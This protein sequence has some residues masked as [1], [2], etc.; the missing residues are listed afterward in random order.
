MGAFKLVRKV[1]ISIM[2]SASLASAGGLA[3]FIKNNL[4]GSI[5][6]TN[7]GYYKTQAG[8]YWT[9]GS[10]KVRWDM[11][12]TNINLFHAEAPSFNVGC[13][14]ID[15]TFG[16]FSYLKFDKLVD[17]L[18]KI[19]SAAP[20]M[21]F[22]MAIM[23][24]CEQCNTIMTNLEKIA[25][26]LNNFNLNACQASKFMARKMCSAI[27]NFGGA[28]DAT[29]CRAKTRKDPEWEF[30]K[31]LEKWSD[32]FSN[33]G[34]E[35]FHNSLGHGSVINKVGENYDVSSFMD[36][37]QFLAIMR[38]LLGDIYGF[39]KPQTD[40]SG[41]NATQLGKFQFIYPV[42][43]PNTFIKGLLYGGDLPVI[44]LNPDIDANEH[45][46]P[47]APVTEDSFTTAKTKSGIVYTKLNIDSSK[48]FVPLF[49]EK[50]EAII[51]KIQNKQSLT[52]DEIAFMNSMPF[53]LYRYANVEATLRNPMIDEISEYLAYTAVRE[54]V[55]VYFRE[56]MKAA[57]SLLQNPD[58]A[59]TSNKK[60]NEWAENISKSYATLINLLDQEIAERE[61]QIKNN[62]TLIDQY[63]DLE[64]QII[65]NSPIWASI[66]L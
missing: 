8:G 6:S 41:A 9:G 51:D 13:N 7:A 39:D 50:I 53:P 27:T 17:K 42:L 40:S 49:K 57:G 1:T 44:V 45:Y 37:D 33:F 16:S 20:A 46:L 66:G 31:S 62:K 59:S 56:L 19:S 43:N 48:A 12:G 18:K 52:D 47:L 10:F 30:T 32:A 22:Q 35:G 29:D 23:A 34:K 25:D 65:R 21:A 11:S 61:T 54:F 58:Y 2:L 38:A 4:D 28:D 60:V 63:K 3:D 36:G 15:A 14:G 26:A 64:Q 24:M 5:I 55:K